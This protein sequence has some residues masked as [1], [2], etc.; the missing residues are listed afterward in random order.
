MCE[1]HWPDIPD[2][3]ARNRAW[4][5][6]KVDGDAGFF[7]RLVAQQT[8]PYFWI[9][10]SDSR[11]P[12]NEIVGL[13]P[14]EMFVHRNVANLAPAQDANFLSTLQFAVQVLK[15]RHIL[16]VGHYGCGGVRAALLNLR[17]GLIDHWL[18]PIRELARINAGELDG[19]PD[20]TARVNRLCELN[21]FRQVENVAAN[22][23]VQQA[24]AEGAALSVHGWCYALE[25]GLVNDLGATVSGPEALPL[26]SGAGGA[27]PEAS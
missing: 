13:E 24:W 20:E 6:G 3:I 19:L 23:F 10:C 11:V 15:V 21:V 9:G 12:A 26:R 27:T 25:D 8:P 16:V 5:K 2:L 7:Q 4:A 18:S 1:A 17:L 22:P 14:G